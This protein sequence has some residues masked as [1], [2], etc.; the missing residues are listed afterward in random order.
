MSRIGVPSMLAWRFLIESMGLS[1]CAFKAD[2]EEF[3]GFDCKLHGELPEYFLAEAVDD[4]IDGILFREAALPQVEDLVFG[5]FV[6]PIAAST[7]P[8]GQLP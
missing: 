5:D 7:V 4:E 6:M 2:F 1:N 3:L 8:F